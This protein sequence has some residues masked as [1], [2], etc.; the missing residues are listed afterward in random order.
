MKS[1]TK[2]KGSNKH[3][4]AI[5]LLLTVV[6]MALI[7]NYIVLPVYSISYFGSIIC[8]IILS[9]PIGG[10]IWLYT[11]KGFLAAILP[12]ILIL[13]MVFNIIISTGIVSGGKKRAIIGEIKNKEFSTEISPID[14]SQLPTIDQALAKNL[15]DKKLGEQVAL[16][17]QVTLGEF[18]QQNVNDKL[19]WVAPLLHSGF[20]KWNSNKEGTPGYI[21]ISATNQM[22]VKLVQEVNGEKT[23]IKYQPN[24]YFGD[25]LARHIYSAGFKNIG[26]TDYS[27]ELDD[28]GRPYWI[29]TKYENTIGFSGAKVTGVISVDAQTG[30]INDY[31]LDNIPSWV[32]RVIPVGFVMNQLDDW[33]RYIHGWWNPSDKDVVQTTKGYN[34]VYNDGECFYYTGMTSAGADESTIGFMLTNTRTKETTFY[35]V[36]GSH[37]YAAMESAE[38]QVQEKEYSATFPILIN[39]DGQATYFMTLKDKKGLVKLYA[40]VNVR[41]YSVVGVGESLNKTKSN[42]IKKLKNRGDWQTLQNS[43]DEVTEIGTVHRIGT[44]VIEGTTYYYIVTVENG[45]KIFI[46][47]LNMS[48]ELPLTREG[49]KIT[50]TYYKNENSSIDLVNFDNLE[51]SQIKSEDEQNIIDENDK[52][53]EEKK[54]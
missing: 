50:F 44:S 47:S 5:I 16:G 34:I 26:R 23:K 6:L 53:E 49:D 39:I 27:F 2:S 51:L 25:D 18:T 31:N 1:K 3:V 36:S 52:L 11:K 15:G 42:Y 9:I 46:T 10:V 45:D 37:E 48:S 21:M 4:T 29:V 28:T 35:K 7:A 17:S 54:N 8:L 38:G 20:F 40:M 24:A 14:L 13:L 12:G 43:S 30:E 19:Y 32:D 33:G 22:D 41:D